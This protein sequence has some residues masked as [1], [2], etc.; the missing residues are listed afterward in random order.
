M[1]AES[2]QAGLGQLSE[3][4]LRARLAELDSKRASL[5]R[6][7]LDLVGIIDALREQLRPLLQ[8]EYTA[9]MHLNRLSE[10]RKSIEQRLLAIEIERK[11]RDFIQLVRQRS[12][13][14]SEVLGQLDNQVAQA[15][16]RVVEAISDDERFVAV[17]PV[18]YEQGLAETEVIDNGERIS[19]RGNDNCRLALFEDGSYGIIYNPKPYIRAQTDAVLDQVAAPEG[20]VVDRY[21]LGI[22]VD[23]TQEL[24]L[25]QPFVLVRP[26]DEGRARHMTFSSSPELLAP[27]LGVISDILTQ[28]KISL[29]KRFGAVT[30]VRASKKD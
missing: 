30:I 15:L 10:E 16:G 24:P 12:Q 19:V 11:R 2:K 8:S 29:P 4:D 23:P 22:R 18:L 17:L 6:V 25:V 21:I 27:V 26:V 1:V 7:R 20:F 28:G 5:E 13:R 9:G 3:G 14:A